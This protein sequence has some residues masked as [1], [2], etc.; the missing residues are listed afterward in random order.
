M[1]GVQRAHRRD[2]PDARARAERLERRAELG[3]RPVRWSPP[4]DRRRHRLGQRAVHRLQLGPALADDLEVPLDRLP[5]PARRAARSARSRCPSS[6]ACSGRSASGGAPACSSSSAAAQ[7][8]G[9][10]EALR[11]RSG[12]VVERARPRRP[13]RRPSAG[14]GRRARSLRASAWSLSPLTAAQAPSS[15]SGPRSGTKVWR[16]WR[17]KRRTC[18]VER[19]ERAGAARV[20]RPRGRSGSPRRPPRSRDRARRGRRGRRRRS[21][22]RGP[23]RLRRQ[24][25]GEPRGK[26][27]ADASGADDTG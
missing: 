8:S 20:R 14:A 23:V 22:A 15:C 19:V 9:D 11:D 10:E 7:W 27:R 4:G 26:R 5:V 6:G 2:E 3:D 1:A 17:L 13:A 16:G 25:L 24:R 21:R 18:G 12:R